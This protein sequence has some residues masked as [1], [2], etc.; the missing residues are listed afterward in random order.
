MIGATDD[1]DALREGQRSTQ[2]Q[3]S[4]ADVQVWDAVP[5]RYVPLERG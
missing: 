4:K 2:K 3:L 1:D 5:R